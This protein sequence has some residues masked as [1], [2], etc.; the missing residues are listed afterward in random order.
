MKYLARY[1]EEIKEFDN[2]KDLQSFISGKE[3]VYF[4]KI[5]NKKDEEVFYK[6][7]QPKIYVTINSKGIT[8]FDN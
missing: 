1:K 2:Y 7:S 8:R 5:T 4:R 6:N 3:D